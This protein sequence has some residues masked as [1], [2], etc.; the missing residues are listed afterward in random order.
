MN[1]S[2]SKVWRLPRGFNRCGLGLI[3]ILVAGWGWFTAAALAA[4]PAPPADK[5]SILLLTQGN[6]R[7]PNLIEFMSGFQQNLATNLPGTVT[8]YIENLDVQQFD[9]PDYRREIIDWLRVKYRGRNLDAIVAANEAIIDITFRARAELWPQIPAVLVTVGRMEMPD[10]STQTNVTVISANTDVEGTLAAALRL[11]PDTRRIAFISSGDNGY[12]EVYR[13]DLKRLED[14]ATNRFEVIKLIGLTMAETKQRLGALPP[15]SIV[16]YNG[17][18]ID[19]AGQ[20]YTTR[21]ALAELGPISPAPIFSASDVFLG[22]GTAGGSCRV[23]S[24]LGGETACQ[25]AAVIRAGNASSIPRRQSASNRL[26]FDWRQLHQYGLD[27]NNLPPGSEVLFRPPTLWQTHHQVLI[28]FTAALLVQTALIAALLWQRRRKQLTEAELFNSRQ[29]LRTVLDTIPQRVFWKD[30]NSVYLGCNQTFARDCGFSHPGEIIGKTDRDTLAAAEAEHFRAD[31]LKVME[32][33]QPR[34]NYEETQNRKDGSPAWSMTNKVPLHDQKGRVIGVLGTF[35]D[36]T[37]IKQADEVLRES[38]QRFRSLLDNAPDAV[39]VQTRERIAY[40]NRATLL[41]LRAEHPNQLIGRSVLDFV[42]PQW[43]EIVTTRMRQVNTEDG[44]LPA[45][46]EEYLRLDGSHV[47]VEVTA[48]PAVFHGERSALIF[49]RDVTERRRALETMAYERG[50]LRT[51]LD[52]LPDGVYIKDL[53]SRFLMANETLA[54]RFGKDSP[55]QVLGL[56]DKDFFPAEI[57]AAYRADEEKI[58]AGRAINEQEETVVFTNG[59][60]RTLLTTKVPFRN[61]R[62]EICGLVG[63]GRDITEHKLLEEQFRQSQKMEAFGQLAGGVAHDFN[64]LL[65][66]IEGHVTLLQLRE[67]TPDEHSSSLAEIAKAAERAANLTRQLLTFSRRQLFQPKPVDLNEVVANTTKMLQRL[68][69]EHIGLE[70]HFAPGGAP[71]MADRNMMEQILVNLAVNS[72]DAMPKGGCLVIQT[73]PITISQADVWINPKAHPGDFIRL[74][75]TD[76]GCGIAPQEME[77]IFEPFFT[78]KEVGKGTGLGLATVFGI[79]TQHRGWIEVESKLSEGTTF[80]IHLP[81]LDTHD[82][83]ATEFI[84]APAVRGGHETILLVEDEAPVRSLARTVLERKGYRIIEADSGL[85]AL[86]VWPQHRDSIALLFTDM[87]MPGGISGRE[88]A[89]RLQ[90]EKPGLK[91]IYSSGYTDDMLGEGSP[92]RDNPNF[93]E[94]PFDPRKLLKRVRDCLDGVAG[95]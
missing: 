76:N 19:G 48:V 58:F 33:D 87:V 22:H 89:A 36:I 20:F 43:Q 18:W 8:V 35:Q 6:G 2:N 31:D 57:A 49:V 28:V 26:I 62:G 83:A 10:I 30:R 32:T 74:S 40:A 90:A 37:V 63:I 84:Q 91:V 50:L 81:R 27:E 71:I 85:S 3:F 34:L 15:H 92:L 1:S 45:L 52:L 94:K 29:M 12:A 39:Y 86:E 21:D 79:V 14:F 7:Q 69:G 41:L 47:P 54:R 46:E 24:V 13:R 44:L 82:K 42:A 23:Y 60:K 16:Y 55:A 95:V 65:T 70:T 61:N 17:I 78:T 53:D 66:V 64:N 9:S 88:L 75:V 59:Q 72:R 73:A 80:C 77:R 67:S 68:I 93:L 11:R 4:S 56:S 38:D 5:K 51:L 25:V